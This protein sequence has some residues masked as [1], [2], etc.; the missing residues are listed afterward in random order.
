MYPLVHPRWPPYKFDDVVME[1]GTS[2]VPQ[3]VFKK[4]HLFKKAGPFY[5]F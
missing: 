2:G 1:M 5:M 3:Q 4:G